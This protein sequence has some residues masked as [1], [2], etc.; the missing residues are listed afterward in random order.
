MSEDQVKEKLKKGLLKKI[1][2]TY[3]IKKDYPEALSYI[4]YYIS[5]IGT[6]DEILQYKKK[7]EKKLTDRKNTTK[8]EKTE[9]EPFTSESEGH[10]EQNIKTSIKTRSK[11]PEDK[12]EEDILEP[13][14]LVDNQEKSDE[15]SEEDIQSNEIFEL[16]S[17]QL[18][19]DS[20]SA[21]FREE[22][23]AFDTF[24]DMFELEE[25]DLKKDQAKAESEDLIIKQKEKEKEDIFDIEKNQT[26]ENEDKFELDLD[27]DS[28]QEPN[29]LDLDK[30]IVVQ[31][32]D[33]SD[34]IGEDSEKETSSEADEVEASKKLNHEEIFSLESPQISSLDEEIV[35]IQTETDDQLKPEE[36]LS[37][38]D[39]VIS[40]VNDEY[41][42]LDTKIPS[43]DKPIMKP[44]KPA[45][46]FEEIFQKFSKKQIF[47]GAGILVVL[48]V[49]ILYLLLKNNS[50]LPQ[51]Q[52][53]K[54]E[55]LKKEKPLK[56]KLV[57]TKKRETPI[58]KID[59][60]DQEFKKYFSAA[61]EY[62]KK[63]DYEKSQNYIQRAKTIKSNAKLIHLE[64]QVKQ[65]LSEKQVEQIIEK[66]QQH[67]K[68]EMEV[69]EEEKAYKRI[70]SSSDI[71]N[72]E[73]FL[74]KYPTG[75]HSGQVKK[76]INELKK[77]D[78]TVIENQIRSDVRLL[79]TIQLR[80]EFQYLSQK[81][82]NSLTEKAKK[83]KNKYKLIILDGD[84]V[85]IDYVTG[86]MWH[87]W[88]EP[89]EFTKAKWWSGRRYAGY[90]DWRLPTAEEVSS[91]LNISSQ[92]LPL[93]IKPNQY[94]LWSGDF[95]NTDSS[96][97]WVLFLFEK[98]FKPI[99]SYQYK[100]LGSVRS[101][102]K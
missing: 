69:N 59:P 65:K 28:K 7:I 53:P 42:I 95:N 66:P 68:T 9:P 67:N 86:L 3:H 29:I 100:Y 49:V 94:G 80:T 5:N 70:A 33:T 73:N 85:V 55:T 34:E 90:F 23:P 71:S 14:F 72:L 36:E 21:E 30:E 52:A 82:I 97:L 54:V 43:S 63:G 91:L 79:K 89:M 101:L 41:K 25:K 13:E 88:E 47:I 56:Q 8:L 39:D 26:M 93:K 27:F 76:R 6:T 58:S 18:I 35:E 17:D 19:Q 51:Y 40:M 24:D 15:G 62:Y 48:I 31:P 64:N 44:T 32:K 87:F 50:D 2:E 75:K 46:I 37:L 102:M 60:Q 92:Y 77:Q 84:K 45:S 99:D 10:P 78:R 20:D 81:D 74:I 4:N 96:N 61:E 38:K 98:S 22:L 57:E 11:A 83:I 16:E 1:K 12:E